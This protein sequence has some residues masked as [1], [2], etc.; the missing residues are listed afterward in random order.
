MTPH[1]AG[2]GPPEEPDRVF[3]SVRAF[4]AGRDPDLVARK[5]EKMSGSPF[6]FFRGAAHLFYADWRPDAPLGSR[7]LGDAPAAWAVGDLHLE[8]FGSYRGDNRLTYFDI[9]DFDEAALAP[10]TADLTRLLTSILLAGPAAGFSEEDARDACR[11]LLASYRAALLDGTARWVERRV[12]RGPARALLRRVRRQTRRMLLTERTRWR[13]GA[14]AIRLD[15]ERA[16]P[17]TDAERAAVADTLAAFAD[18]AAAMSPETEGAPDDPAAEGA[19]E[20]R[21]RRDR[22][23]YRVL[24]VARRVAGTGS[25]GIPRYV[26]LVEGRGSPDRHALLDLK[27][28]RPSV[29]A[30][31]GAALEAAR[32]PGVRREAWASEAERVVAVQRRMQAVPPA[33]LSALSVAL[34]GGDVPCVLRELQ[35]S[36][37]RVSRAQVRRT[38]QVARFM[39]TLGQVLAWGQ[40]RSAGRGG[41]ATADDLRE[42]GASLDHATR[43]ALTEDARAR[44]EATARQWRAFADAYAADA[45]ARGEAP[46]P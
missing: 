12:A 20:G 13:R 4:N 6:A 3:E 21:R 23:F 35:P 32:A 33:R 28:A 31:L 17:A 19:R 40:L 43:A 16:L 46:T 9:N 45:A 39:E 34:P 27:A 36:E 30:G 37:D 18:A 22:R 42:W 10:A 2:A 25:L 7:V 5:L 38:R 44:Q 14:L 8:N 24:D 41:S 26:V 15:P 1:D 29:L 11:H